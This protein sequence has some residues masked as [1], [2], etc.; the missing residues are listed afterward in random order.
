[1]LLM[2]FVRLVYSESLEVVRCAVGVV[3]VTVGVANA[4]Q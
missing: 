4:M 3:G 2:L 1:M